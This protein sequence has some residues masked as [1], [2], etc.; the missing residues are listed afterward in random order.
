MKRRRGLP[1]RSTRQ[2]KSERGVVNE[3][4]VCSQERDKRRVDVARQ[5]QQALFEERAHTAA[6]DCRLAAGRT[7][8][9]EAQLVPLGLRDAAGARR[10]PLHKLRDAPRAVEAAERAVVELDVEPIANT[11][12]IVPAVG[13]E[14]RDKRT[15]VTLPT[16]SPLTS[17]QSM[18]FVA[19]LGVDVGSLVGPAQ[20]TRR[21][22]S[23]VARAS[24]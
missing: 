20:R 22:S 24:T 1:K 21:T 23:T 7:R 4:N 3:R 18:P 12:R 17:N 11:N 15:R 16:R 2:S 5:R 6:L 10:G 13:G 8:D 9:G 14:A 19:Q